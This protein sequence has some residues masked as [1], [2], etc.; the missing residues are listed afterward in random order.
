MISFFMLIHC[1]KALGYILIH[2]LSISPLQ[3][4][5]IPCRCC[6]RE[7]YSLSVVDRKAALLKIQ[8]EI[9]SNNQRNIV[10]VCHMCQLLLWCYELLDPHNVDIWALA[11]NNE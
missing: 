3:V 7:I 4:L 5:S 6:P 8:G 2:Q 10:L 11:I 1:S 9:S